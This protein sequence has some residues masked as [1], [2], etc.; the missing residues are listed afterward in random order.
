[1]L[2][3]LTFMSLLML[4]LFLLVLLCK[5]AC[6]VLIFMLILMF[7]CTFYLSYYYDNDY[8]MVLIFTLIVIH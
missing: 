7:M 4:G 6:V 2:V 3:S 5:D 1:M 8:V